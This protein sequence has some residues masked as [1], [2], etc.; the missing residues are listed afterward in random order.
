MTFEDIKT[1]LASGYQEWGWSEF[2]D[3]IATDMDVLERLVLL[4]EQTVSR[5]ELTICECLLITAKSSFRLGLLIGLL[6]D[7][8]LERR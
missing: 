4:V 1:E 2:I 5:H 8:P 7:M 6:M 3:D